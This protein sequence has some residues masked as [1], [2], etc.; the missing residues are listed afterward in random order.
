MR[1][2]LILLLSIILFIN[3]SKAQQQ[4]LNS[5]GILLALKKLNTF[6]TALYIAAH[7][8]DENTR[9]I[10][11]LAN[12][13]C[14]RTGYLSMTRGDGGQNLIGD[15][16][17]ELLGLIRT[18]ELLA[19]R[20]VDGAEQ[21][22]T[23]AN[24]FGFSKNPEET[25]RIWNKDSVLAD[26]VWTIR[27]FRPDVMI[28]RFAT[29]GSGGHGHHTASAILAEEAFVAAA[30]PN[31]FPEQLKFVKPWQ[32]KRLLYNNAARFWNPNADMTGNIATEV[33][34][35]N[36]MLGKSYG[37]LA[38]ESRSMHKSQG[39]GSARTRGS[40]V[41]YFKPIKGDAIDADIFDGI[42]LSANRVDGA[43]TFKQWAKKA[44]SEF[45]ADEPATI[46]PDLLE[47]YKALELIND[48][49]WKELK[50]KELESL[51]IACSGIYLEATATE[52]AVTPGQPVKLNISAIN[53]SDVLVTLEKILSPQGGNSSPKKQLDKDQA[54][55]EEKTFTLN[56][57]LAYN[58]PYWLAEKHSEGL[59][60]V[61]DRMLIGL[62]ESPAALQVQ[63]VLSFSGQRITINK[64]VLY[65]W[66][67]PVDGELYRPMQITPPVMINLDAK[68]YVFPNKSSR[69]VN[70]VL[71]AGK[72]NCAGLL[73]LDLPQNW[74]S[75][76]ASIP[77][78]LQNKDEE[79]NFE[80]E[81]IPPSENSVA[82]L[83]AVAE[84][85]GVK[86]SKGQTIIDYKHIPIQTLF[87]EAEA[88]LVRFDLNRKMQ[89]IGY[90]KGAGD[91]V[92]HSLEQLGYQVKFLS[93]AMLSNGVDLS[94][95]DAIVVGIRAYNT[96]DRMKHYYSK[97]MNY[98]K[99]GGN[100]IVQYNTNNFIGGVK[101]EIGP[102]PFA[103]GRD[104]VTDE[105]AEV[106][107][108]LPKHKVLNS[109]NKITANDFDGWIQERGIYF[110]SD[111]DK[112]Y[113]TPL[114]L[115]DPNEKSL[116]GSTLIT[117]YGKGH[118]IYSGLAFF[119][120]LPAGVPGAYR[121]FVNMIELGK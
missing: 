21:F 47:A 83:K 111:W 44:E 7:P 71:K 93:D 82:Y 95:Y 63:F 70:I 8:D 120:E 73:K 48:D 81:V 91:E 6:G 2:P 98:V 104:R 61:K 32:A 114:S 69:K 26:A 3:A 112:N 42:D 108:D 1:K 62:A 37:E 35:F 31:R 52:Y 88:K 28:T 75:N 86:Y 92:P 4:S 80:F 64:P 60:T 109:P 90:I 29:D 84:I 43:E 50:R 78:S 40:V 96:N 68:A 17:G 97:L 13:K 14:V 105:A 22:F 107:F 54:H 72:E 51:L 116:L 24:D 27:K 106:R 19:A 39:F 57:N 34:Q 76:P 23:R 94:V 89:N 36:P 102:Y 10:S 16:Q 58:N 119:R 66:V 45:L 15:Q 41:E 25:F 110:A 5:A 11:W 99:N 103:I 46:V 101:S 18:Q 30:D 79:Q 38:G 9:L 56:A 12:E 74:R 118:F 113:E 20:R 33:G 115:N 121:L 87:L 55:K 117:K 77:F 49:Y 85:D 59:F 53:R 65:R 67:D 100:L